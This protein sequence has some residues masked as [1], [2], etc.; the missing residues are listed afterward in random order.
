MIVHDILYSVHK[1]RAIMCLSEW[2][3]F[4]YKN[5]DNSDVHGRVCELF[6]TAAEWVIFVLVIIPSY[7]RL[8]LQMSSY[9]SAHVCQ[10]HWV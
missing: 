2:A 8:L 4:G 3:G 10:A 9:M 5:H 1:V 7:P 6:Y